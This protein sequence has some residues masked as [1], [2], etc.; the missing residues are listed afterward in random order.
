MEEI[1]IK[2]CQKIKN[3]N[4]KNIKENIVK[5]IE[6]DSLNLINWRL[7]LSSYVLSLLVS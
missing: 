7:F 4:L 5:L 1:H 2:I 3:K 6:T